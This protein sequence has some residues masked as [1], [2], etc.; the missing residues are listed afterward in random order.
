MRGILGHSPSE[1]QY[2]KVAKM[3]YLLSRLQ[4]PDG[5]CMKLLGTEPLIGTQPGEGSRSPGSE[6]ASIK[7]DLNGELPAAFKTHFR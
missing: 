7:K 3:A 4:G 6:K 2:K 5:V 1:D